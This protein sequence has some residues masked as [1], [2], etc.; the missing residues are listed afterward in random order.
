MI[1]RQQDISDCAVACMAWVLDYYG[2]GRSRSLIRSHLG[3]TKAG[4]TA[5]GFVDCGRSV[6]LSVKG[7]KGPPDALSTVPLPAIAHCLLEKGLLH[8]VVLVGWTPRHAKVM[9]PAVGKVERW[10]HERFKKIWTGVLILLAPG[11]GFVPGNQTISAGRR[12]VGLMKPHRAVLAQAFIGA[13]A[14]TILGLGMSIYVQKIVDNVI[15][16]GNRQLLNLL[17]VAMLGIVV[18]KRILGWFQ[19]IISIRTAQK[20]DVALIPAYYRHLL[21]L[22]Q[23]FFDTM[24]V[25]EIVS[26]VGDAVKIRNFINGSLLNLTI[27]P[28]ILLFS[29]AAMFVYSPQL[30]AIS[31]VLLPINVI[32]YWAVNRLNRTYQ[33]QMMERGAD[34]DAQ[35][36]ESLK[37]QP[38]IRGFQLEADAAFRTE[39][40]LVRVL[41]TAWAASLGGLGCNTA[42]TLVTSVYMIGLLWFG[43]GLVL[44]ADLT[45][46][47]LMSCYTLAGYLTGPIASL[48]GLNASI[49]D[50][51]IATDRLFDLVDMEIEKDQGTINFESRH[52]GDIRFEE[53]TFRHPSRPAIFDSL[54]FTIPKGKITALIGESG[55]GKSS[56]LALIQRL[57]LPVAGRVFIGDHDVQ[58]FAL[59]SLRKGMAVVHQQT[60]LLSGTVLENL[61][62]GDY[63]PDLERVLNLCRELGALSFIEK[64]PQGFMTHLNENGTNLSGGQRQRLSLVRALYHDA[65]ILLLDEP[66]SALDEKSAQTFMSLLR[67]LRNQGRTIILAAHSSEVVEI[68]DRIV[69]IPDGQVSEKSQQQPVS[70]A[71]GVC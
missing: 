66:T 58:Y 70:A 57:Y 68:A 15:P 55:G 62:P 44:T 63:E 27:N 53:V 14:T 2:I 37:A 60:R 1:Y 7:V 71:I 20:I 67:K 61:V 42:A 48:I 34:F 52:S 64:L 28:L 40:R 36:V 21:Q 65:P 17:G 49:Q 3:T 56:I 50:T 11:E 23:S 4:T 13:I 25:G 24:R 26:R 31:L 54:S 6:G 69:T 35:L 10:S 19:S 5:S 47:Q 30:A 41:K 38:V 45:P 51:L 46:G 59:A 16:D 32:I 33:R 9:D 29:L 22:P 18:V 8:Y 39:T 12:L 43:S